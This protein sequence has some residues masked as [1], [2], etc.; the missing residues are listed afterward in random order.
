MVSLKTPRLRV[1]LET[2]A[3]LDAQTDNRDAVQWDFTRSRNRWPDGRDAPILWVTFL[4]WNALRRT[5]APVPESFDDFNRQA[6]AV[7]VI[8]AAGNLIN[9]TEDTEPDAA[10]GE[11]D[12]ADPTRPDPG[13]A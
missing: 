8:D 9:R 12:P 7:D 10:D 4:A 6:I 13:P 3:E 1:T 5:G 2:G 11:P